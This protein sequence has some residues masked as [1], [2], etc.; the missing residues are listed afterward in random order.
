MIPDAQR[1][2]VSLPFALVVLAPGGQI[3][4]L[5]PAAEQLIGRSASRLVGANIADVFEFAEDALAER[6]S[7]ADVQ[8]TAHAV[9]VSLLGQ[10]PRRLDVTVAP[11]G[12]APGW[13]VV[14]LHEFGG[15]GTLGGQDALL[16]GPE[17]LAHEIKNPLAGIRGAAQLLA[18]KVDEDGRPLT[19]LIVD[20]VDRIVKLIDQMQMLSRRSAE[21]VA[22]CNL[23]EA[24]RRGLAVLGAGRDLPVVVEKFDPSLPPVLANADALV[25]V[26]LNLLGNA[27]DACAHLDRPQLVV[28][29]RFASGLQ[30]HGERGS[31]PVR[32]PIE[33]RISD[34]GSG[35]APTLSEHVFEPFVSGKRAGQGLGLALV[36]RLVSDMNGRVGHDRDEA[37]GWTHFHVH[38]PV[39]VEDRAQICEQAA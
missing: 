35:I 27:A 9:P 7:A 8:I 10:P 19:T 37:R 34:N 26:V 32:L 38:L 36:Q 1:Q 21:P 31:E 33:L 18:R 24:I 20:E 22:A 3:S 17:V 2:L 39:A 13:R 4:T 29:T 28:R 15:A 6:M 14:T 25:Q 23:H 12:D 11:I 16:R 5:N 30:L